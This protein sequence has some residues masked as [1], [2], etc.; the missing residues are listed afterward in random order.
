MARFEGKT[1]IVTGGASGIGEATVKEFAAEGGSVAIID[2]NDE[3]GPQVV[4]E[5]KQSGGKAIYVHCDV[6]EPEDC[7]QAVEQAKEAFK[8]VDYL[9]NSAATFLWKG[10]DGDK[11]TWEKCLGVNVIGLFNMVKAY[12]PA[13]K[14][15]GEGAIVNLSSISGY[16]AQANQWTYNTSKGAILTITRCMAMDLARYG[17]RVNSVSPGF[18]WTPV[19]ID[20][21]HGDI[22]KYDPIWGKFHILKRCGKPREV[23]QPI[24]FLLSEEASF[25]TASDLHVDGGF[26]AVSSEGLGQSAEWADE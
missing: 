1:L 22:E 23:A 16:I 4:E 12:V 8:R 20:M 11:E 7:V 14:Q 25:I 10:L 3:L 9:V 24:L 15:V 17:I 18:I 2:I 26:L 5:I 13:V 19:V 21:A 6:A